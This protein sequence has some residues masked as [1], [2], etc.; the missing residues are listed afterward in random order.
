MKRKPIDEV[1]FPAYMGT[2]IKE[3][4]R[5][6]PSDAS[7]FTDQGMTGTIAEDMTTAD[8]AVPEGG[9]RKT[10]IHKKEVAG[11]T[12][13]ESVE[14]PTEVEMNKFISRGDYKQIMSEIQ[15]LC[16]DYGINFHSEESI[17]KQ[18]TKK[19]PIFQ[20]EFVSKLD[21]FCAKYDLSLKTFGLEEG[22]D[23][24]TAE[25]D[26]HNKQNIEQFEADV[27]FLQQLLADYRK[28]YPENVV[29]N[30][31]QVIN[32]SDLAHLSNTDDLNHWEEKIVS[33]LRSKIENAIAEGGENIDKY[34]S[35]TNKMKNPIKEDKIKKLIES[36]GIVSKAT[37]VIDEADD[38]ESDKGEDGEKEDADDKKSKGP[39]K[40]VNPF[41]KK[42]EKKEPGTDEE[43]ED[44][45]DEDDSFPKSA[46]KDDQE[47]E[48]VSDETPKFK[49]KNRVIA[50][51]G[52]DTDV[53]RNIAV[54]ILANVEGAME[55]PEGEYELT[56]KPV[57]KEEDEELAEYAEIQPSHI[58]GALDDKK[59]AKA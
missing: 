5:K 35:K 38:D 46:K 39:K 40:G 29:N 43:D 11:Y 25:I 19:N 44:D 9:I 27:L 2:Q 13:L 12:Y 3:P 34:E 54:S 33:E 32:N 16:R 7:Y 8:I 21:D 53:A 51:K 31:Q 15:A 58:P 42:G 10:P 55:L 59:Q 41:A 49:S 17:S 52:F 26:Y 20:K 4:K 24:N 28:K 23:Y 47:D 30:I 45:E 56:F 50:I 1:K 37:P 14:M 6:L 18:L 57:E 22:F 48:I 36:Y